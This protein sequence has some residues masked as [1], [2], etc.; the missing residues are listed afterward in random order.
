VLLDICG[1]VQVFDQL[2]NESIREVVQNMLGEVAERTAALGITLTF[3]HSTV[4]LLCRTGFSVETGARELRRQVIQLVEDQ[5]ADYVLTCA[6]KTSG[7]R[8]LAEAFEGAVKIREIE[9]LDRVPALEQH[10]LLSDQGEQ[11]DYI[12]EEVTVIPRPRVRVH[13]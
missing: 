3:A 7:L 5:L 11:W 6:G 1:C 10:P 12:V 9:S 4:D 8:L 2:R 13:A